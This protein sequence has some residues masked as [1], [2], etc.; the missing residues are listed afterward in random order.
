M[1]QSPFGIHVAEPC[2]DPSGRFPILSTTADSVFCL[3]LTSARS[4]DLIQVRRGSLSG[5]TAADLE[6]STPKSPV[7]QAVEP[8]A[9]PAKYPTCFAAES[10]TNELSLAK[11]MYDFSPE[12]LS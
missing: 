3:A 9:E 12:V 6:R 7:A 11:E 2:C 10:T 8:V 1:S 4:W 5:H